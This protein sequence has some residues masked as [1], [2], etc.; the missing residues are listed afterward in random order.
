MHQSLPNALTSMLRVNRQILQ[1]CLVG[2]APCGRK[3]Y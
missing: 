3:T 1:F 2:H